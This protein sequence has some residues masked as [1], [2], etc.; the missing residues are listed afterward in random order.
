M[1]PFLTEVLVDSNIFFEFLD[2]TTSFVEA[3]DFPNTWL[4]AIKLNYLSILFNYNGLV[5][6]KCPFSFFSICWSKYDSS[7]LDSP[8]SPSKNWGYFF[9]YFVFVTAENE[10]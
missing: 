1:L 3:L 10:D 9:G 6:P 4:C 2:F 5:V 8:E 7:L